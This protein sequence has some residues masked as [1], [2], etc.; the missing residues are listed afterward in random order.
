M[1]DRELIRLA[2]DTLT[3]AEFDV[4]LSKRMGYGRRAGSLRLCITEDAWRHR[5]RIAT[6]KVE[7]ALAALEEHAA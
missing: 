4:W 5:L 6:V 7:A 1:T 3:R 2:R